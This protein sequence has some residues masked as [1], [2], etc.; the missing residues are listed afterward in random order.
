MGL[1][2]RGLG[3]NGVEFTGVDTIDMNED[4]A[5]GKRSNFRDFGTRMGYA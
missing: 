2:G 1:G 3:L 5:G 4:T